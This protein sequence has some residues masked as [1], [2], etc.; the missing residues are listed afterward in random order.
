MASSGLY[1]FNP[2][3]SNLTLVAYSRIGIR[4]TAITAEHMADAESEANLV[5]V[6]LTNRQ[7]LLWRS[8]L[9]TQALTQGTGTY[10]LPA[11]MVAIQAAYITTTNNGQSFDRIIWPLSA[12]EWSALPDKTTQAPPQSYWYD[13]LINPEMKLWPV[14]DGNATYTLKLQI[15][16]QIQDVVLGNGVTMDMPFRYLD[17]FVAKL[18]HRLARIYAP[19]KEA[20]RKADADEAWNVAAAQD[21]EDVPLYIQPGLDSYYR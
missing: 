9:Y 3:A 2:A 6:E 4:R 14:P 18:A 17:C 15:L 13:R 10:V 21:S 5:Q 20:L 12:F 16:S 7:P 1:Q 19:D 11:R 8:E